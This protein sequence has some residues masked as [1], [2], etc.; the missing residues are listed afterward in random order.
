MGNGTSSKSNM[1]VM[2]ESIN[3]AMISSIQSCGSQSTQI[4]EI[5]VKGTG[6]V[7]ND[8]QMKQAIDTVTKCASD[9]SAMSD[10]TAKMASAIKQTA[11]SQGVALIGALQGASS[12]VNTKIKNVV[13][14]YINLQSMQNIVS[15]AIQKQT[16][17]VDGS[18]NVLMNI[19][20]DQFYKNL[21]DAAASQTA[22]LTTAVVS[23][24][25]AEQQASS[26]VQDPIS[27]AIKAIGDL[28]MGNFL[29]FAL[30][31][32]ACIGGFLIWW[33]SGGD[34]FASQGMDLYAEQQGLGQG[35][36]EEYEMQEGEQMQ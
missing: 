31:M 22:K 35:D 20:M 4:Q 3:S 23:E 18:N 17:D 8:I 30:I 28:I 6:N 24:T 25:T 7:L 10:M 29:I 9:Q 13:S 32:I 15:A 14:N 11:D 33:Q 19:S 16:I 34:A 36:Q 26:K 1:E 2:N 5:K 21:T 27:N 12:E